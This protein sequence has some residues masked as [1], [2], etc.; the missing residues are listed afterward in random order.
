MVEPDEA[1]APEPIQ[2]GQAE[3]DVE[4]RSLE[5]DDDSKRLRY[6]GANCGTKSYTPN[7]WVLANTA[8]KKLH[9]G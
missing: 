2:M 1:V 3:P 6:R 7:W 5:S 8:I 9:P 4:D